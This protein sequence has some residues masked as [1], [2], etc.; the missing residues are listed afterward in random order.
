MICF[1]IAAL[2]LRPYELPETAWILSS[3]YK[4]SEIRM[5]AD[6]SF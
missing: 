5:E 3:S 2:I 6:L 4:L 1:W